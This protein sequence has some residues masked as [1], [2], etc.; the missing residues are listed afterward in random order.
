[1]GFIEFESDI[2]LELEIQSLLL[3]RVD[4]LLSLLDDL[5]VAV[6][7]FESLCITFL[8]TRRRNQVLNLDVLAAVPL[9]PSLSIRQLL[10]KHYFEA[11]DDPN[12]QN[13]RCDSCRVLLTDADGRN[14]SDEWH[15]V[16]GFPF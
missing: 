11:H 8:V 4:Q 14:Q 2:L 15:E 6:S 10:G 16:V 12:Y 5:A 7:I 1:M 9:V 13:Q 3:R